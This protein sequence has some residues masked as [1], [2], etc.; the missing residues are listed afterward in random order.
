MILENCEVHFAKLD[1]PSARYNKDNP[2]WELQIRTSDREVKKL[3][4]KIN[5][6]VKPVVPDEGEPYFR[7]NLRKRSIKKDGVPAQPP[8][9]V[10]KKLRPIDPKTIGNGSICNVRIYQYPYNGGASTASILMGVQVL[11]HIYFEPKPRDEDFE[12]MDGETEVEPFDSIPDDEVA[13]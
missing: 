2:T 4:E 3:W 8:T 13:F 11:K 10:D 6:N 12:E 5:L 1:R 9:V 7:V